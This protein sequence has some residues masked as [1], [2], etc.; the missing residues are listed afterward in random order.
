MNIRT[1]FFLVM[2]SVQL[3]H[4][5][6]SVKL[7][8]YY[9][10]GWTG[11]FPYH[12]TTALVDSFPEREPKWGWVTS[13]QEI[14]DEQITTAA[15]AGLSFFSFCWYYSGKSTYKHEPL[16][17]ALSYYRNSKNKDRLKHCLLV[18][19]H[20]GF[21]IGPDDWDLVSSEWISNFKDG[22]YLLVNGKP[23]LIFFSVETLLRKFGSVDS[24]SKAFSDLRQKAVNQGLKGVTLA[25][26]IPQNS[27]DSLIAMAE[28]SGI[29]VITGYN[30]HSAA[31]G[32]DRK[33]PIEQLIQAEKGVWQNI[34]GRTSLKYIPTCT[35]NW[36]PRP[37]SNKSNRYD[38]APY[39]AGYSPATVNRSISECIKW[40]R[41]H[42]DKVVAEKIALVYAWNE[43]GEG[44]Y[45][46]P[47][48]NGTNMLNGVKKALKAQ[49]RN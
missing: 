34:S 12:I 46:T 44:A 8:A 3:A 18:A 31:F 35:L 24:L 13:S 29:D 14:V 49:K 10:D 6:T 33:I 39:Y 45:L 15:D 22:T 27:N 32:K 11:T 5:Q 36:D 41:Q 17:R 30:F 26:C 1:F 7:G 4:A 9:F 28:Q 48:K 20:K 47:S 2:L 21:E 43:N 37:W 23:I 16:N 25:A 42:P 40:L 19:N 38:K